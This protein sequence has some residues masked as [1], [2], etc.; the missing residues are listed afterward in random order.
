MPETT[1]RPSMCRCSTLHALFHLPSRQCP[2]RCSRSPAVESRGHLLPRILCVSL[3][4]CTNDQRL[5][6]CTQEYE[7]L[8][9]IGEGTYGVVA[10]C[11]HRPTGAIVA[12][13]MFKDADK[14]VGPLR[15]SSAS[16]TRRY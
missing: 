1:C 15:M 14:Q 8:G 7:N 10:R 6:R 9:T 13:K 3:A 2:S 4:T 12:V 5:D 16:R 11:R